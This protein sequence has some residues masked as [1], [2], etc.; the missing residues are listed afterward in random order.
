MD[1]LALPLDVTWQSAPSN[2]ILKGLVTVHNL[3]F[4]QTNINSKQ[5]ARE[6]KIKKTDSVI[7]GIMTQ[8]LLKHLFSDSLERF[9]PFVLS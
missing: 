3:S 9:N 8:E 2:S 6:C 1:S 7:K 5:V 4:T